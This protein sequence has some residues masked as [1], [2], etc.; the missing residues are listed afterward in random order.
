MATV[1][2][3]L[4]EDEN[5]SIILSLVIQVDEAL[6]TGI[7]EAFGAPNLGGTLFAPTNDA[8]IAAA[9][10]LGYPDPDARGAAEYLNAAAFA[11]TDGQT[12]IFLAEILALHLVPAELTPDDLSNGAVIPTL[13]GA[14]LTVSDGALIDFEPDNADALLGDV[15][16]LDNGVLIPID[17]LLLPFDIQIDD[18]PTEDGDVIVGTDDDDTFFLLGGS[19]VFSG[20]LGDDTGFGGNGNDLL[21]GGSGNDF[22]QGGAGNDRLEGQTGDDTLRGGLGNDRLTGDQGDDRLNGGAG[23][24]FLQ[25]GSGGDVLLG[26][27]GN[28]KVIGGRGNDVLSGGDGSD[29]L[30]GENGADEMFGEDGNDRL[31]GGFGKDQLSGDDGDDLLGGGGGADALFGGDGNDMLRGAAGDDFIAAGQGDDT[32]TGGEGEDTYSFASSEDGSN[33]ITDFASGEDKIE[34]TGLTEE[35]VIT[36]L[37]GQGDGNDALLV[38]SVNANWSVLVEDAEDLSDDDLYIV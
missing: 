34:L 21:H 30:L 26:N 17:Q 24:D 11:L 5:F 23:D 1:L 35:E 12:E 38:S 31:F 8:L 15:M 37:L 19:D 36:L 22:F 33:R 4:V 13:L 18:V 27:T 28:D 7:A 6:D 2:E 32:I 25:G 9:N 3:T 10:D 16:T 20:G 29:R 14:N